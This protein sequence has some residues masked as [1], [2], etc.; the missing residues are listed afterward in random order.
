MYL[1]PSRLSAGEIPPLSV[2]LH[3]PAV[4]KLYSQATK[5]SRSAA[6]DSGAP[7][8][9]RAEACCS[10]TLAVLD[11]CR[12]KEAWRLEVVTVREVLTILIP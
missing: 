2:I 1:V 5:A 12:V 6:T 9:R 3:P 10:G 8:R 4:R 11:A 7:Q